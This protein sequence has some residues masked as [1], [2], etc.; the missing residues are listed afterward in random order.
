MEG[1][2]WLQDADFT[3]LCGERATLTSGRVHLLADP[4][5]YAVEAAA[6]STAQLLIVHTRPASATL[7]VSVAEGA[8]LSVAEIFLAEVFVDFTIRQHGQSRCHL[9]VAELT[10]ANVNY[11]IDLDGE[12]A[13]SELDGLF[14]AGGKEHCEVAV[15]VNHNVPGCCSRSLVKGVAG[16]EA[17]GA[18]RGLVYVAQDAQRTDAQQTSRNI[19]L[20]PTARIVTKPQLEIYADDVKCSHGATVGQLDDEAILYMR[21]RG[22]DEAQAR[23]LQLEGFVGAIA[24]QCG[25]EAVRDKLYELIVGKLERM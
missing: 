6:G 3:P 22:L 23:R 4:E 24:A 25:V 17:K 21:Q 14:L 5:K 8:E 2:D 16:G 15:R 20:T 12:G 18:F 1:L 9:T 7:S 11:G 13:G 10:S 19:E